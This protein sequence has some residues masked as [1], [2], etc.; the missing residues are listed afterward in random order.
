M[1]EQELRA[2]VELPQPEGV[3]MV[4]IEQIGKH[5]LTLSVGKCV[6]CELSLCLA[7][8]TATSLN[9]TG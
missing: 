7:I 9:C 2:Q 3:S 4:T 1:I 6:Q 5:Y 8:C